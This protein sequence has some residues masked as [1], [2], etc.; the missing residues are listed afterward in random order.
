VALAAALIFLVVALAVRSSGS[1]S[2]SNRTPAASAASPAARS[3]ASRSRASAAGSGRL[4]RNATPQPGWHRF[5][6]PVPILVYHNLGTPPASEPS[7]GLYVSDA[8]FATEMAWLHSHGYEGVTL[9]EVMN[10][11]YRGG[12]LPSK[13]IVVTFD[14]G[15]IPQAT[16]APSVMSKYGWPGVLNEITAGH[17]SNARI[18]SLLAIG[19]EIDSHSVNHPDMTTL[20]PSAMRYQLVA[21]RRFLQRTFHIPVNSFC[22]PSNRYNAAVLAAIRAAGYENATTENTGYAHS[23][24]PFELN[25]F[26]IEGGVDQLAGDLNG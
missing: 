3:G 11:W 2:S 23:S 4:V 5:T 25:R 6:G 1:N 10:A 19:W 20:S 17:L 18:R 14:N 15:Y 13:P 8:D 24:A 9:D 21:S 7:P 16:F 12:T 22:I 26:E